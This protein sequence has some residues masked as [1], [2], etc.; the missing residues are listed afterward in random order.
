LKAKPVGTTGELFSHV[1][2]HAMSGIIRYRTVAVVA[3]L[4]LTAGC[5]NKKLTRANYDKI[6]AGMTMNEVETLLGGPGEQEGGDL[7]AAEGSGAAGAVGVGDF[8]S[9]SQPRSKFKTYKWGSSS[10]WIKV[11]FLEDKVAP[12]NSKSEQGLK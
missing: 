3:L 7:A 11:T 2:G 1:R 5:G 6:N 4:A 12:S 8:Q 9:M 10:K